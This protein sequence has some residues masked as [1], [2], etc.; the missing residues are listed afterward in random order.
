[1][2]DKIIEKNQSINSTR[3]INNDYVDK[4]LSVAINILSSFLQTESLPGSNI[5]HLLHS[6]SRSEI[7]KRIQ[8]NMKVNG[9]KMK[10]RYAKHKRIKVEDFNVGDNAAAKVPPTDR[11]KCDASRV[12]AVVVL[13]RGQVQAKYKLACRFGTIESFYTA[14]SL[15]SSKATFCFEEGY[16]KM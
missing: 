12:L 5:S 15:I 13:K 2:Y 11:G 14:S 1:M 4:E 3:P 16:F 9:D 6:P 10:E 7:R 8:K